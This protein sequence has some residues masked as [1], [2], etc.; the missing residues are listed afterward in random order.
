MKTAIIVAIIVAILLLL[1]RNARK[2]KQGWKPVAVPS[3]WHILY[4]KG[5][6]DRPTTTGTGYSFDFPTDPSYVGYVLDGTPRSLTGRLVSRGTITGGP[7]IPSEYPGETALMSH[8]IQRKGDDLTD[9]NGRWYSQ[10][11]LKLVEGEFELSTPLVVAD[12]INVLGQHDERGFADTLANVG[13]IGHVFGAEI[14]RGHGAHSTAARF[15]LESLET[16]G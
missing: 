6:P 5:M 7:I 3:G 16:V 10:Q 11:A 14:G 1:I 8:F 9:P 2:P 13:A 15:T 12:W 4:S